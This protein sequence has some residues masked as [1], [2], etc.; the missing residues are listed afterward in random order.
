MTSHELAMFVILCWET[1]CQ[2]H[3]FTRFIK[4]KTYWILLYWT[5]KWRPCNLLL[6]IFLDYQWHKTRNEYI[7]RWLCFC[8]IYTSTCLFPCLP[9]CYK[10]NDYFTKVNFDNSF[11]LIWDLSCVLYDWYSK[12]YAHISFLFF[13]FLLCW[14]CFVITLDSSTPSVLLGLS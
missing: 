2:I 5:Y 6:C 1:S 3:H 8:Y 14:K 7:L 13:F 11:C 12:S 4:I 9:K 10:Y